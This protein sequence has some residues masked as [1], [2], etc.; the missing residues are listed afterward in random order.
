[1][2][3]FHSYVAVY[4]RVSVF[5]SMVSNAVC[6]M[7]GYIPSTGNIAREHDEFIIGFWC[8]NDPYTTFEVKITKPSSQVWFKMSVKSWRHQSDPQSCFCFF[9]VA[10]YW[11][12]HIYIYI[13]LPA[14][15]ICCFY[16]HDIP[17]VVRVAP[18]WHPMLPTSSQPVRDMV[19]TV[20]GMAVHELVIPLPGNRSLRLLEAADSNE[21]QELSGAI[22]AWGQHQ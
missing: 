13:I 11:L 14:S 17:L 10:L 4:Q 18:R 1:M 7:M 12:V 3:I 22:Q 2:V 9:L 15:T 8:T 21:A 6:P 16:P 19:D 20:A 5:D